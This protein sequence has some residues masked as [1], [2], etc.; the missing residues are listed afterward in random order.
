M[1][2]PGFWTE[3]G[4][5]A[6]L[7]SPVGA[8]FG[9]FGRW[10]WR[11][12]SPVRAGIPVVCV[13]NLVAGGAG[14][15]PVALSFAALL[16]QK[17]HATHFLSRGYGGTI[18]GPHRVDRRCD[19]PTM[20][21]D[22][23]LLLA[24]VSPT[25]VSVDRVAGVRAAAQAGAE[26]VVMDDG[27]QNPSIAKDLSVVVIDGSYGFGNH[28]VIPAGPLREPVADGLARADTVAI[29]GAEYSNAILLSRASGRRAMGGNDHKKWISNCKSIWSEGCSLEKSRQRS[30]IN[31]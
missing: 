13:G 24:V 9:V 17:G 7:L 8:L 22:E 1:K 4:I 29:L 10:R 25:W 19:S 5:T 2:A 31:K 12:A 18:R 3:E 21:G 6:T 30:R 27:F 20:V 23:A 16:Q 15:T 26:I 28:H 11:L 14:K